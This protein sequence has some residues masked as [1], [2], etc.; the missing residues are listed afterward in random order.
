[1]EKK[2]KGVGK[3][4]KREVERM[5]GWEEEKVVNKGRAGRRDGKKE[6]REEGNGFE[7]EKSGWK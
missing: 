4:E 2:K 1:V 3:K 7:R 5:K 6:R